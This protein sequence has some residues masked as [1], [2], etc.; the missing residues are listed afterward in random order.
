MQRL[1]RIKSSLTRIFSPPPPY[2]DVSLEEI[3]SMTLEEREKLAGRFARTAVEV[4]R[5]DL[6]RTPEQ[7]HFGPGN[8]ELR[9]ILGTSLA[10]EGV[11]EI[12]NRA[13]PDCQLTAK[14]SVLPREQIIPVG[15]KTVSI[16][17]EEDQYQPH[18]E[19]LLF[20][21]L[22]DAYIGTQGNGFLNDWIDAIRT[23][24]GPDMQQSDKNFLQAVFNALNFMELERSGINS[25]GILNALKL[26]AELKSSL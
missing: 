20:T 16:L 1:E 13:N 15:L 14:V 9:F 23:S 26:Q 2:P 21:L 17:L 3:P 25:P 19:R 10:L 11:N 22:N 24:I 4:I 6:E 12:D 8:D 18:A 7:D 5:S